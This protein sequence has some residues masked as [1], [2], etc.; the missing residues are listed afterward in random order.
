MKIDT[1][2]AIM[3]DEN[4]EYEQKLNNECGAY[5]MGLEIID[6]VIEEDGYWVTTTVGYDINEDDQKMID[7][8]ILFRSE[9]SDNKVIEK[10]YQIAKEKVL[11]D[12][13]NNIVMNTLNELAKQIAVE[14]EEK[15]KND[16]TSLYLLFECKDGKFSYK[17]SNDNHHCNDINF[18]CDAIDE[19]EYVN[20]SVEDIEAELEYFFKENNISL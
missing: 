8:S 4:S 5:I 16:N 18:I 17:F 13:K 12:K 7:F 14:I 10:I 11:T 3:Y 19:D 1:V 9:M 6:A 20:M 15:V 2:K